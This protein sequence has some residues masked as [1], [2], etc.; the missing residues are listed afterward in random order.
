MKGWVEAMEI[1]WWIFPIYQQT[2]KKL[3]GGSL[4][5]T[6][7]GCLNIH[8][9]HVTANNY[10]NN[11]VL[12]FLVSDM[13]IVCYNNYWFSINVLDKRG[14]NILH[15][16]LVLNDFVSKYLKRCIPLIW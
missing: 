2:T 11:N 16:Y 13:K 9:T 3:H 14:K 6:Y 12:F 5:S 8:G 4:Q 1:L 15:H 10:T 7:T